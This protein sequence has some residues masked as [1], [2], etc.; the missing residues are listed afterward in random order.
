M[1]TNQGFRETIKTSQCNLNSQNMKKKLTT[2][3]IKSPWKGSRK[4]PKALVTMQ[5]IENSCTAWQMKKNK[6]AEK[7]K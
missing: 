4:W 6:D 7:N 3:E 2:P 5:I 1:I